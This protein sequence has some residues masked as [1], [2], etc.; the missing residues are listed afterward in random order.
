M[1]QQP[2]WHDAYWPLLIQLYMEKP[3][4]MKPVYSK[5]LVDLGL[6]LHVTPRYLR[7]M[8]A[9]LDE[10]ASPSLKAMMA[11]CKRNPKGFADM[12]ARL[13]TMKGFGDEQAFF[14]GVE[15]VD[16]FEKDYKPV[17]QGSPITPMML[18][19]VLD[20]YFRLTP[21]TMV[22]ATPEVAE[23]ARLTRVKPGDIAAALRGFCCCDPCIKTSDAV[24]QPLLAACNDV[25]HRYGNLEQDKLSAL[26]CRLKDYFS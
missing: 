23:L 18:V 17:M 12:V 20:L 21:Q 16:G 8:M 5:P 22:A 10:V 7:R 11:S 6:E 25:W 2:I 3:V 19:I 14:D 4:G 26:A 13:K 9:K 15:V 1:A 24:E